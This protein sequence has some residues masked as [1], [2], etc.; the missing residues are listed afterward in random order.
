VA[1]KKGAP[2]DADVAIA[3][4][5]GRGY[6]GWFV[7]DQSFGPAP[8]RAGDFLLGASA[9]RPVA[10]FVRGGAWAHS[11]YLSRKLQGT[12]RSPSF[13][14]DR[15][16]L[17]VYA[18]GKASRVNVVVEQFVMIQDPL[19]GSL[20][21]IVNNDGPKW[22]TWD[23]WM[24]KGRQAYLEFAD[25]TTQD[26]HDMRPPDGCGP[27]GYLAVGRVVLSDEREPPPATPEAET[28]ELLGEAALESPE[29]LAE[30]YQRV[31]TES[32]EAF[33]TGKLCDLPD[34]E[35]RASLLAWLVEHGLLDSTPTAELE[36]AFK[37]FKEIESRLP[38][39]Q[40]AP[41]M[42]EGTPE[43][44]RV[45]VRGDPKN[46]GPVQPRRMLQAICG[47]KPSPAPSTG[48]GRLQLARLIADPSNPLTS[49][50]MVNRVWHHVFGRGV[51]ASVD[52][53]GAL[54][55]KP[56]HP[57]LLDHLADRFVKEGWSV[58]R[59]VRELVLSSAF[60]M[61]SRSSPESDAADPD[62]RLLHRM[63]VR[64]LEAEAIRD[65]VLAIS[66]RLD[67]E[68]MYGPGVEVHLTPFMENGYGNDYGRPKSSGP[69]DGEGRRSVYLMVR[70]NFLNPMLVAFDSPPPLNTAGRRVTS[71]VPAQA[72][73]LMNDPF[74][75]EQATLWARRVLARE[76]L[77]AER[78]VKRMYAEA[79]AR[80]PTEQELVV[81]LRFLDHHAEE[82]QVPHKKR[83]TDERLW[84]D[85][86][87]VLM[88]VKEF[89][90]LN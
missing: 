28:G 81:A 55:E 37:Q 44:G 22:L 9:S 57:E 32:L 88:N 86:A 15:R 53:F 20:R 24:W 72:L 30:H 40:R 49:R 13:D 25:T 42:T 61:D 46:L 76:A 58:K 35:A 31:V 36:S 11:G 87:H 68:R 56:S 84:A 69:M 82:L 73:I 17:H 3:D 4:F 48:S 59:L 80:P 45:Y 65:Q 1:T 26:L 19:Y 78:R 51:V 50:V 90:Y 47:D 62:N 64:R 5:A 66:G 75:A 18:A 33:R 85:F 74:V 52:N 14:I 60:R 71:N 34:T 43:D 29:I 70:R 2:R 12:L 27:E 89:I 38:E 63:P 41:A 7:E 83:A 23:L 10:T 79:L 54:G 39:P 67:R 8:L 77:D 16:F 6:E 21:K